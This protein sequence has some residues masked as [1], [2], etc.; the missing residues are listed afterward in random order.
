MSL[1]QSIVV[2][3]EFTHNGVN[4]PGK[5]SRGGT[6]GQYVLRY[7]ARIDATEM[8][9]PVPET[10]DA[11]IVDYTTRYMM[12][13]DATEQLKSSGKPNASI[14][15]LSDTFEQQ[16]LLSGRSFGNRGVSLSDNTVRDSSQ[17]IQDAFDE[18]HSVQKIILSFTEDYLK[19]N[20]V[21]SPNYQH[22]GRGSYRGHIDQLKLRMAVMKGVEKMTSVGNYANPEWVG[23]IQ[24][25]TNH[26][27]AHLALVDKDFSPS[28]MME[29]GRDKGKLTQREMMSL[30]RGIQ[31][32]LNEMKSI[33]SFY[34]QVS[35]ERQNVVS[36]I[37]DYAHD[38]I[39]KNTRLQILMAALP[40][41][42]HLWRFS[43]N[44][45]EMQYPNEL[46]VKFVES[47]FEEQPVR[48]GYRDATKAIRDY[49][50]GRVDTEGID[51]DEQK[52]LAKNGR[53]LLVERS[54]NGLYGSLKV[55][56]KSTL[57]VRTPILDIQSASEDELLASVSDNFDQIGFELR[58]RGYS[59]RRDVHLQ[60][61]DKFKQLIEVFD[62]AHEQNNV[63]DDA[64]ILRR[65][66]EEEL[67]WNMALTDKYRSFFKINVI[68]ERKI[69]DG[70]QPE[71]ERLYEQYETLRLKDDFIND[72]DNGTILDGLVGFNDVDDVFRNSM[73]FN[74][75]VEDLY[76]VKQ[77]S[78]AFSDFYREG[79]EQELARE[80]IAYV[81]DLRAYTFNCFKDG[82]LT[83]K[84]WVDLQNE[85]RDVD[86]PTYKQR[87]SNYANVFKEPAK[88]KP[89][90][91]SITDEHFDDIKSID[92]H[93]LGLDFYGKADRSISKRNRERFAESMQW[94][95]YFLSG[96]QEFLQAT[97]QVNELQSVTYIEND[98]KDM[99]KTVDEMSRNGL[100]PT[101]EPI[102]SDTG[103]QRNSRTIRIDTGID[104]LS[105]LQQN[106]MLSDDELETEL[107]S[108]DDGVLTSELSVESDLEG[109]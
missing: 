59:K 46:A 82:V 28:R 56:D 94:R 36:Y 98:V 108:F 90:S 68:N 61:S 31:Y 80:K 16:D 62:M 92:I 79:L 51:Q 12:R 40:E 30:R 33:K 23:V 42:Q 7:M 37:K 70:Y 74:Q 21:L 64:Y 91:E 105:S 93:H 96:A 6:P 32:E 102:G 5:G 106:M 38:H 10:Q 15:E 100:I 101:V 86:L 14:Y 77:G 95:E 104:V 109:F 43:T 99:R 2:K 24:V 78:R 47:V 35:L 97:G 41:E 45:K 89:T 54:V 13:E 83:Q 9:T 63:S 52:R 67:E 44:R 48:S 81:K 69:A 73:Q 3:N 27:H 84:D 66:Y 17:M 103:V 18:G 26:V 88:P 107:E 65:F 87:I 53:K 34:S 75:Y 8:V 55:F 49:I 22:K 72:V 60:E 57:D 50:K 20:G 1:K 76:G 71:Y 4:T 25:D 39:G 11:S 58:I 19:D 85:H 29:D